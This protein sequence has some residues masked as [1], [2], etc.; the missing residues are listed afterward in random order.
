MSGF[1]ERFK[2]HSTEVG[3]PLYAETLLS[4]SFHKNGKE[5]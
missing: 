1:L 4:F 2:P 5:L 3:L